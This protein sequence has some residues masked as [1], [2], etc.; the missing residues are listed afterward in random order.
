MLINTVSKK[1]ISLFFS[2]NEDYPKEV[3]VYGMSLILTSAITTV[4]LLI[5]GVSLGYFTETILF[6]MSFSFLRIFT[7]GLHSRSYI[8]CNLYT[9]SLFLSAICF[10]IYLNDTF[11]VFLIYGSVLLISIILVKKLAP[12]ENGQKPIRKEIYLSLKRKAQTVVVVES[13]ILM[14]SILLGYTKMRIIF[15]AIVIND[16]LMIIGFFK[17]HERRSSNE[18]MEHDD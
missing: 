13:I 14:I 12:V 8:M 18:K 5:I 9:I 3:Y 1:I 16:V 4:F 15:P 2:D 17:N 6:I 7:G 10:Y 11:N